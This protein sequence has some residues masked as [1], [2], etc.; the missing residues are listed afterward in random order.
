MKWE[1]VREPW[2][3]D[4]YLRGTSIR[5]TKDSIYGNGAW[6]AATGMRGFAI[7]DNGHEV[8]VVKLNMSHKN[9]FQ[10]ALGA[11]QRWARQ[12]AKEEGIIK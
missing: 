3:T 5:V 2:G 7:E 1:A 9:P 4:Y 8:H 11:A 12:Y 10:Q 6:C